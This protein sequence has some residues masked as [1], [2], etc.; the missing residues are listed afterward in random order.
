MPESSNRLSGVLA[1]LRSY[2][3]PRLKFATFAETSSRSVGQSTPPAL[4]ITSSA[5]RLPDSM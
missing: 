4:S 3:D 5:S 1:T 2:A